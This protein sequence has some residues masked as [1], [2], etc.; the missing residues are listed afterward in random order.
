MRI[1]QTCNW[2]Q[3]LW[4]NRYF[5]TLP[6]KAVKWWLFS[7]IKNEDKSLLTYKQC[8]NIL[9]L[10]LNRKRKVSNVWVSLKQLES[11]GKKKK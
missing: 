5:L 2:A 11:G 8:W 3:K 6:L 9:Q 7:T 10:T 1:Y 4:R